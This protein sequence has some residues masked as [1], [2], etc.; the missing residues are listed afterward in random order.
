MIP[1]TAEY[2]LRAVVCL[3]NQAGRM[4]TTAQ[5][6]DEIDAPRSYL[7]KVMKELSRAGIVGSQ[8]GLHGG[9]TLNRDPSNITVLRV[10]NAVDAVQ[11]CPHERPVPLVSADGQCN[12]SG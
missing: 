7:A 11:N 10:V 8:R 2:A 5:I 1:Q 6:A 3:G 4:R 9:F 12:E